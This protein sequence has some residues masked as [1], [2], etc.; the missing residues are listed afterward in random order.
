MKPIGDAD[1]PVPARRDGA[2]PPGMSLIRRLL[3][4]PRRFRFDAAVRLLL[5][6]RKRGDVASVTRFRTPGNLSY[7]PADMLSVT[8]DQAVTG[9]GGLTGPS[10]LLPRAYTEHVMRQTRLGAQALHSFLDMLAHRMLAGFAQAGIKYRLYRA[11]EQAALGGPP[12]AP[13]T[14]LL[15]LTGRAA[16]QNDALEDFILHHAGAFAAWPRSAE[17]L[18]AILSDWARRPVRVEQFAGAWLAIPPEEQT[19]LPKARGNGRFARLGI[20]AALGARAWD[21]QANIVLRVDPMPF[22]A[23]QEFM[24]LQPLAGQ[25]GALARAYLGPSVAFALNPL[26]VGH[27]VP[28]IQLGSPRRLGWD[29]WLPREH[30][31]AKPPDAADAVF[32]ARLIE[33]R[34]AA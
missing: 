29:S 24:P 28:G 9:I 27:Q 18:E 25:L 12:D 10:G 22:T 1:A 15:A 31:A 30:R 14:A 20:D 6:W 26:L 13:R 16:P 34:A 5:H 8:P 32:P 7:A 33:R 11:A 19:R 2:K 23:F 3:A 17:R 4:Q 21:P